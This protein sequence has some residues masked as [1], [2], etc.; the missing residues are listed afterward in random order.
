MKE[1]KLFFNYRE[2]AKHLT[3][4]CIEQKYVA[5]LVITIVIMNY[6]MNYNS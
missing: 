3:F 1:D 6:T 5:E 4:V 2:P